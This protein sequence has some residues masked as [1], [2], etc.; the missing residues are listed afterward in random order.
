MRQDTSANV[1]L[2]EVMAEA[3]AHGLS[4]QRLTGYGK[5]LDARLLA[6]EGMIC[7]IVRTRQVPQVDYPTAA[8]ARLYLPRT[9]FADFLIYVAFPS[10][11]DPSFYVVPRGA[12]SKDTA[13]SLGSLEQYRDAW[14]VLK[15]KIA[16]DQ[17]ERHFTTLNWQLQAVVDSA[18]DA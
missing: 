9:E 18:K 3:Q 11:G 7:Q 1:P 10:T 4:V 13:W 15:G 14:Q 12:M 17:T 5:V 16:P 6:I 8:Y 2:R